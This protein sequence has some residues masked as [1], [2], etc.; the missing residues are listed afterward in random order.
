[1]K[2]FTAILLAAMLVLTSACAFADARTFIVGFDPDY[3]PY[4]YMG[5]DG[6]YTGYDI[7]M[8]KALCEKLGWTYSEYAVNWDTK[9]LELNA[10]A[11]DCIWSGFTINGREDDYAWSYPYVDNSQVILTR[12]DT[13]ITT[14]ADLAGRVVGVQVATS[15]L[16]LLEGELSS[17]RDTFADLTQFNSYLTAVT[18]LQAGAIDAIAIDIGVA[19]FYVNS[20]ADLVILDETLATEQYGVGFRVDDTALR[21]E[22]NEGLMSLVADGT[23]AELAEKYGLSDFICLTAE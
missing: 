7:E 21:D 17:I 14:V 10:Y 8:A 1:M 2:R 11:C 23:Y 18:E 5:D 22:F 12:A 16:E 6:S 3:A 19:Q 9:D 20:Y 4:S 13:G 15:A